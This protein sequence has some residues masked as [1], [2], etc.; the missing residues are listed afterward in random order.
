MLRNIMWKIFKH[1]FLSACLLLAF[2]G[3]TWTEAASPP[4][5]T[6]GQ[7][8]AAY[9]YNFAKFVQWP[10]TAFTNS[11]EPLRVCIVGSD[12]LF[13][14]MQSLQGK[15]VQGRPLTL[16]KRSFLESPPDAHILFIARQYG[17]GAWKELEK[18]VF[19]PM[20]TIADFDSFVSEGGI[21]GFIQEGS[22]LRFAVNIAAARRSGLK[23]SS[24]LL[25]L[26][27]FVE[28]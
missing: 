1:I 7:I 15:T 22:K 11:G 21:I 13:Q 28:E 8:K 23:L 24:K 18:Q 26:A 3:A 12:A 4:S 20:L 6:E 16:S 25:R 14:A 5:L 2:H 19:T 10:E 17:E 27:V 9:I